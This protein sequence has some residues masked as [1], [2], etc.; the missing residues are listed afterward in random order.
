M[1]ITVLDGYALNPGDI[2]WQQFKELGEFTLYD[3]TPPEDS[4]EIIRRIGSSDVILLNKV[5]ITKKIVAACP[6]LKYIGV[7]ATGYNVVDLE[8]CRSAGITVTNIPAYGT[9]AVAQFTFAL[10]LEICSQ[11]GRHNASV[12]KGD[13]Q[14]SPDFTY[15]LQP[16]TELK[17]KTLGLIGYGAIAQAVAEI[18]HAFKMEVVYWNHRSKE[19]QAPWI[20]QLSLEKLLAKSDVVSL[21]VPLFPETEKIINERTLAQMK[22]G[23]ILLNTSRGGLLDEAAVSV[24]LSKGK[25]AACGV[26]VVSQE[27][28]LADNPLL[29]A[30][31]CWIT[32]HIAWAPS[33]TRGRLMA[34][35][36]ENLTAFLQ[37]TR[38]NVVS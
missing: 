8:A 13:W 14:K 17:G 27:P 33:E 11:V 12:H 4:A 3:R 28:I 35:A 29:H 34:I 22:M 1:K 37:G 24:A 10:L 38:Q 2:S 20:K 9:D 21:H 7:L 30:K 26:D 31:N 15:W 18:A 6:N 36:V 5:P 19:P 23:S 32:P 25:L 16:L